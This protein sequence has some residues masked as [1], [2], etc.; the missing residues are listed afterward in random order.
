MKRTVPTL[1][2]L[3]VFLIA[4]APE[5]TPTMSPADVQGTAV[6]AASTIAAA[7]QQVIPTATPTPTTEPFSPIPSTTFTPVPTLSLPT[8]PTI[9]PVVA[10][11]GTDT[12]LHPLNMTEAGPKK[13]VRIENQSGG[14]SLNLS[15]NLYQPNASGQCGV[16]SWADKPK[17]WTEII[18]IAP[19]SWFAYAWITGNGGSS[20]SA[21][22]FVLGN[23]KSDDLLRLVIKRDVISL[24][25]P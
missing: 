11:T 22:S 12:C 10:A 2:I 23:G 3:A 14:T 6:A 13:R 21:G 18:E 5:A 7:T 8:P 4:C 19:G 25:S 15:L 16:L 24:V 17:N 1:L 9:T 20:E